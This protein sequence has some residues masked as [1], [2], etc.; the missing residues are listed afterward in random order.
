WSLPRQPWAGLCPCRAVHTF[1]RRARGRAL[2][3]RSDLRQA[4]QGLSREDLRAT[5][6]RA[7][8]GTPGASARPAVVCGAG[9]AHVPPDPG[10]GAPAVRP[11]PRTAAGERGQVERGG[12]PR[13][14]G[15]TLMFDPQRFQADMSEALER[16]DA[17]VPWWLRQRYSG[18][19]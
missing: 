3:S 7:D 1:L 11:R 9:P 8:S 12:A 18:K 17:F 2:P 19:A 5:A 15:P 14:H 16:A 13:A 6:L 10:G 4:A